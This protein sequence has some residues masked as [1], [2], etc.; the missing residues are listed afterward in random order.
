MCDLLVDDNVQKEKTLCNNRSPKSQLIRE[1]IKSSEWPCEHV[2]LL[3]G[4]RS[5]SDI[6]RNSNTRMAFS[7]A[8]RITHGGAANE[9]LAPRTIEG[10]RRFIIPIEGASARVHSFFSDH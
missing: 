9:E 3:V 6:L 8:L 5:P 1:R 10:W 4:M 2:S 7:P